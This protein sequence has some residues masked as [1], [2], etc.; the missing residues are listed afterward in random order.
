M[1]SRQGRGSVDEG[2]A[3]GVEAPEEEI[4]EWP[5]SGTQAWKPGYDMLTFCYVFRFAFMDVLARRSR[6]WSG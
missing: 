5:F 2:D 4:L 3:G 6:S 1:D